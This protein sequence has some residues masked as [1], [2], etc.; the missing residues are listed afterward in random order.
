MS[1]V[2]GMPPLTELAWQAQVVELARTLGWRCYHTH[3]SQHSA[4]GFPDLTLARGE[5]LLFAE[6]KTTK[7][8]T[9]A[10]Q[11]EWLRALSVA[12][13][14]TYLWR[15]GEWDAVVGLLR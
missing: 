10:A 6:L 15:P 3:N 8:R 1:T 2:V 4:A 7:G 9:T 12:G 11:E 13:A 14:E 5:R